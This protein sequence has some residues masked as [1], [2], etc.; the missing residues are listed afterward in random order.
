MKKIDSIKI[1]GYVFP[2]FP[3]LIF[4]SGKF[5]IGEDEVKEVYN[6]G[7]VSMIIYGVKR[8]KKK[9]LPIL[10]KQAVKCSIELTKSPF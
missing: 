4:H 3:N 2:D 1:D 9:L 10:R 8:G 5:W 7:S 6:N